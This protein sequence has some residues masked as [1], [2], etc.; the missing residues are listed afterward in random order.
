MAKYKC[1]LIDDD[2]SGIYCDDGKFRRNVYFGTVSG[3]CKFWKNEG[4]AKRT[5]DKLRLSNYTIKRVYAGDI[6]NSNGLVERKY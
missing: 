1:F 4:W 3:S 6:V 5:A 2:S